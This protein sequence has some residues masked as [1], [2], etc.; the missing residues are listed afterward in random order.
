MKDKEFLEGIYIKYEKAKK[1]KQDAFF[2]P[3]SKNKKSFP[4]WKMVAIFTGVILLTAGMVYAGIFTYQEKKHKENI[5]KE[6]EVYD[7]WA[8]QEITQEDRKRAISKEE[9]ESLAKEKLRKIGYSDQIEVAL[10]ELTKRAGE[11]KLYWNIE[12]KNNWVIQIDAID[13]KLW[14]FEDRS[15]EDRKISSSLDRSLAQKVAEELYNGLSYQKEGYELTY[16][17]KYGSGAGWY[18]DFSKVYDGIVNKYQVVRISFIPET[19]QIMYLVLFDEPFENNPVEITKEEAK[20]KAEEQFKLLYPQKNIQQIESKLA[21]E[22][23]N[24]FLYSQQYPLPEG[25]SYVQS[26]IVRKVWK[27]KINQGEM[28][29][30][31]DATTGECI[32]ADAIK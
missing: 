22:K 23:M 17:H 20:K 3:N 6:P 12:T 1:L 13:K 11:K 8:S 2:N 24:S 9:A 30:F 10:A 29:F 28:S 4:F 16:L 21:I 18:A 5:W 26:N 32:G 7:F 27:V 19:K 25:K 31:I 14:S 15:V